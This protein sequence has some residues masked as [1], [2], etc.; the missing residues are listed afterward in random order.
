MPP[1]I[2]ST[3]TSTS[4]SRATRRQNSLSIHLAESVVFLRTNDATGRNRYGDSQTSI[5]RGLLVLEVVKPMK[6]S[7]IELEL[8]AKSATAWPEGV[9]AHRT[10]ITEIHRVFEARDAVWSAAGYSGWRANN[11]KGKKAH[12]NLQN[13]IVEEEAFQLDP[14]EVQPPS[15]PSIVLGDTDPT[16][17]R[18]LTPSSASIIAPSSFSSASTSLSTASTSATSASM[19]TAGTSS[20]LLS[21]VKPF[22][23]SLPSKY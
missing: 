3:T 5:V 9:G 7:A 16:P 10:D 14:E 21:N 11:G 15:Y 6:I 8:I 19:S 22:E 20:S 12:D 2:T 23:E 18:A 1:S 13:E 17:S 4:K